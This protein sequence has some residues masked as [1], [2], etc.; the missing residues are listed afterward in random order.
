M[1]V[2]L[3]LIPIIPFAGFLIL[4]LAGSRLSSRMIAF[5]GT[6]TVGLAAVL[7]LVVGFSYLDDFADGASVSIKLWEWLKVG[8][9]EVDFSLRL[10]SLSMVFIFVITFVGFLIHLFSIEFMKGDEGY[11]RFFAYM[12]LFVSSM[13]ILVLADNLLLLYFGWEG[14]GLCSYLLIGFWYKEPLNGYAARKAF[15]VTRIGDVAMLLGLLLLFTTLGTLNIGEIMT[16]VLSEWSA[17]NNVAFWASILLLGGAVGKSAQLP[18]HTWL[19]DAMAGPSPVSALIH[20]AT[21]VTAGVYL[22]ARTHVLFVLSPVIM[23]MVAVIG[24]LTLLMAGFAAAAQHDLK[25]ILAYSTISQIGYMFLAL[26]V[27]AWSAAIFHFMV[28]AFFK[29]LLFLSAGAVIL[30]LNDEHDIFRMGGLRKRMPVIFRTFLAGS[31]SLSALPLITAGFYSKD[32]ILW[33]SWASDKGSYFLWLGGVVG[34]FIT[35]LYTF[36]MVFITFFG[37]IK[38]MPSKTPGKLMKVPLVILAILSLTAGFI[39][40][41][42]SLGRIHLFTGFLH[43]VLPGIEVTA[44]RSTEVLFQVITAL[45]SLSGIYLAYLLFYRKSSFAESFSH[46]KINGFFLHGW[47]FDRLYDLLFVKPFVWL[48]EIDRNDLFDL[49]SK[50]ISRMIIKINKLLSVT[51]NGLLRWYVVAIA[52]GIVVIMTILTFDQVKI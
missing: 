17:G 6:F 18:L 47:Q 41:P 25:R 15:I 38:T 13:L 26:G 36:R 4:A 7:S 11:A 10:D 27:G 35:S 33:F 39:E 3:G 50:Q 29:A 49:V 22:I 42:E 46:S 44:E 20:A 19:P 2:L 1:N 23:S 9:L 28:H 30:L 32:A 45:I 51:Q 16:R 24:A 8:D 31:A 52:I 12:N 21:M 43:H 40:L 48:S 34:A 14:V 37:E 5:T